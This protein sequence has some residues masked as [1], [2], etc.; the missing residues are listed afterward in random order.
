MLSAEGADEVTSL[1]PNAR[2]AT[3]EKAGHLAA[4][5]NPNSTTNLIAGFLDEL[6]W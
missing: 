2:L 3:V 5:D 6:R 4:G 1:I